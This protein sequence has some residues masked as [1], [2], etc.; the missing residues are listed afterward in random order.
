MGPSAPTPT[1]QP[2][3]SQPPF[4]LLDSET[5][6]A[7]LSS[8]PGSTQEALLRSIARSP[9]ARG[10]TVGYAQ[11]VLPPLTP[12][13]H[14]SRP[15]SVAISR[16]ARGSFSNLAVDT[17]AGALNGAGGSFT[18]EEGEVEDAESGAE[19]PTKLWNLWAMQNELEED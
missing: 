10:V 7:A 9:L 4:F 3:S 6:I 16:H 5:S 17:S 15:G 18:E 19:S 2:S 8:L 11:E 13:R 14:P 1:P 12:V